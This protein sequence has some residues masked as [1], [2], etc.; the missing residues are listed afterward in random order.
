MKTV[1][2]KAKMTKK[3][4]KAKQEQHRNTKKTKLKARIKIKEQERRLKKKEIAQKLEIKR[5]EKKLK[6]L[7][8]DEHDERV[9]KARKLYNVVMYGSTKKPRSR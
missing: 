8:K 5:L 9:E 6:K 7:Q 4:I 1:A 2:D 3:Q